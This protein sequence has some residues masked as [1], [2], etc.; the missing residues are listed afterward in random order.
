MNRINHEFIPRFK[1]GKV[2]TFY[3]YVPSFVEEM[4]IKITMATG[5]DTVRNIIQ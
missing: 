5:S 1:F 2:F 4:K 3:V